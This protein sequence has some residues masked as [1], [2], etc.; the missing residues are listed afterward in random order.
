LFGELPCFFYNVRR[1]AGSRE[2]LK[3][4]NPKN[5]MRAGAFDGDLVGA[6]MSI[7]ESGKLHAIET[8]RAPSQ[9][10]ARSGD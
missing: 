3:E 2:D 9:N 6:S 10:D 5:K 4:D 8:G 1:Q 7:A